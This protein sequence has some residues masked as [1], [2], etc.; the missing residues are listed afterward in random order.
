MINFYLAGSHRDA[1]RLKKL[2]RALSAVSNSEYV[3]C[4]DWMV[5]VFDWPT[6]KRTDRDAHRI[7]NL[8]R[9]GVLK[10][11]VLIA[12][13]SDPLQRGTYWELGMAD[14]LKKRIVIVDN[15]PGYGVFDPRSEGSLCFFFAEPNYTL[16]GFGED[17]RN[18]PE[19]AAKFILSSLGE[20]FVPR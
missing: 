20:R 5:D 8:N 14:A 16:I 10:C 6:A 18:D 4:R 9:L 1:A 13:I 19:K 2:S 17:E 3:C 7:A 12:V 11:D 15:L